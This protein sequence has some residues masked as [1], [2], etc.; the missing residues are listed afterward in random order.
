MRIDTTVVHVIRILM[1]LWG[2]YAKTISG[3]YLVFILPSDILA[4]WYMLH[5]LS[6]YEH[7]VENWYYSHSFDS[8]VNNNISVSC[9]VNF[10][11]I[12]Y[13]YVVQYWYSLVDKCYSTYPD[14]IMLFITDTSVVH[15]SAMWI[16]LFV[17]NWKNILVSYCIN[18]ASGTDTNHWG[19]D[20]PPIQIPICHS[21]L[22][23][24]SF[25]QSEF[26]YW[27]QW[28]MYTMF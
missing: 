28:I 15:L 7:F 26:E 19:N 24:Q 8:N 3:S 1:Q 13:I 17:D 21:E 5:N 14:E 25:I 27:Y 4:T 22:I 20:T 2:N 23:L 16:L 18:M 12:F 9:K 6:R 10:N 11:L